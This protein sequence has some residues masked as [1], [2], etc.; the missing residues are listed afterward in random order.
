MKKCKCEKKV[1]KKVDVKKKDVKKK[2]EKKKITETE[3]K[4]LAKKKKR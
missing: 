4:M 2:E 3:K 1:V